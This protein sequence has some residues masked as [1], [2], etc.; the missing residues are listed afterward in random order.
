MAAAIEIG[1]V[2]IWSRELRFHA[3]RGQALD[4]AAELEELGY[5]ALWIPDVGGDVLGAAREL[6]DATRAVT[7][8][9]GILNIWMHDP[10]DV[11]S[12]V[13]A[14]GPRFLLGLGASHSA[15]VDAEE[16]G[17]YARPLSTMVAYL[18]GLDANSLGR[19]QRV[20][21]ALGPRMLELARDRAAG[22]HPYLVTPA[23]TAIARETLG[24]DALLAPELS[25]TLER[26]LDVARAFVAD[27]LRLPNYVNNLRRLGFDDNDLAGAPSDRLVRALVAT[28]G[29]REIAQRVA[30]HHAA[31][32]DHVTVQVIGAGETLPREAWREL[33]PALLRG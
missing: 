23:H 3:D 28:G 18:D 2:G 14:L 24:P 20:L 11:A 17:R 21:A 27:Y 12:G 22:A 7:I 32:A 9:T 1:R 19:S 33:A 25:V 31:G 13:A 26:D 8:A 15:V 5:G 6:L 10:A 29:P 4:A 16:P 30:E